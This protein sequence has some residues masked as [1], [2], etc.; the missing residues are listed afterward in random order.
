M[1]PPNST[2]VTVRRGLDNAYQQA[3]VIIIIGNGVANGL[4]GADAVL[5]VI[6]GVRIYSS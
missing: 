3:S 4:P 2:A 6:I 1:L 5:V